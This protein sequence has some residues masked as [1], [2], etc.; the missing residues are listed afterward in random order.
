VE[1]RGSG[2]LLTWGGGYVAM[3]NR[4]ENSVESCCELVTGLA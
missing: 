2:D 4:K 1:G 3:C